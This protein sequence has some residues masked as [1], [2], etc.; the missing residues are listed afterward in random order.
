MENTFTIMPMS[1]QVNLAPGNTYTGSITIVNPVDATEDFHYK[2][3]IS[4]YGVIG[5][6]YAA[7]LKP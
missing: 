5:E 3:D 4:P 1:H 7:D 2:M 6:D